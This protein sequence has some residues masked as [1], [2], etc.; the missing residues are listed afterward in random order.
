MSEA[1]ARRP[2]VPGALAW[3]LLAAASGLA[4]GFIAS[5]GATWA[6]AALGLVVAVVRSDF[7]WS[8]PLGFSVIGVLIAA[9]LAAI[10]F[11]R[12]PARAAH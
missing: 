11:V 4:A 1:T 7:T 9:S 3:G 10:L 8:F 2:D 6:A 5:Q 12:L